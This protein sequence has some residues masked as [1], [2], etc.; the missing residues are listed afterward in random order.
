VDFV[1]DEEMSPSV[2]AASL[3]VAG[4]ALTRWKCAKKKKRK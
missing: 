2:V 4:K 3:L 1:E